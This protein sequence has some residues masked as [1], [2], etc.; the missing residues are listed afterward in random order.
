M[1]DCRVAPDVIEIVWST[2][3]LSYCSRS[4]RQSPAEISN[5]RVVRTWLPGTFRESRQFGDILGVML[6]DKGSIKRLGDSR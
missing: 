1:P 2:V 3:R 4:L 6:H 5:G